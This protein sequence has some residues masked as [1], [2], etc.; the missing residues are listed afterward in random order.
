MD[1]GRFDALTRSL[2]RRTSRRGLLARAVATCFLASA[3]ALPTWRTTAKKK[4]KTK[5]VFNQFGCIDVGQ[6]CAGKADLCC[7]GV[8]EGKKPKKGK[9]DKRR[10]AAHDVGGCLANQDSCETG[11]I[12]CTT[13]ANKSGSCQQTTGGA[14]YCAASSAG[15]CSPCA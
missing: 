2:T 6:P 11:E 10:C 13:S 15:D 14:S 9:K 12:T 1:A 7:S 3:A 8:C 5:L 4:R